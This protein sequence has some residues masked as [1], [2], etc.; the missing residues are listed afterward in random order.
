MNITDTTFAFG[1]AVTTS[2]SYGD[3]VEKAKQFLKDEGFGVLC[4]IDVAATMKE[5]LGADVEPYRILGACN[6]ALAHAALAH[7]PQLGLLLPCNVVVQR[8]GGET[9]VSAIDARA[10]LRIVERNDM[11]PVAEEVTA[12]LSRVLDRFAER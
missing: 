5:K 3:A 11:E 1:R 12:R 6:P 8:I 7:H 9:V 10:L 4:E 2:L